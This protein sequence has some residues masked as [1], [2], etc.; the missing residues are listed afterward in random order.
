MIFKSL[1][2]RIL[3]N[4]FPSAMDR[5][6]RRLY[7]AK[8]KQA[9]RNNFV[10]PVRNTPVECVSIGNL[11]YGELNV[12]SSTQS[13][14]LYMGHFCSIAENVMFVLN[15]D[16]PLNHVTTYPMKA[17]L[18]GMPEATSKGD[19]IIGDDVW[20]GYGSIILSGVTIGRGAVVGAGA[21]VTKDVPPYAVV[22]GNPARILRFRFS[23]IVIA[24]LMK[25]DYSKFNEKNIKK[26]LDL[27]YEEVN[28]KNVVALV[29]QLNRIGD[30]QE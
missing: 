24:E 30:E 19:I 25:I 27:F 29:D 1:L 21:V 22:G 5:L 16:H 7:L 4:L 26:D 17:K 28:E 18:L 6:K 13:S 9:N 10:L 15:A 12:M 20:F 3:S 2:D 14:R 8:W 11:C 23:E